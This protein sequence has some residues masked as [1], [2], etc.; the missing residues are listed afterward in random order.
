MSAWANTATAPFRWRSGVVLALTSIAG[1]I[2]FTWPLFAHPR[3]SENLAHA[4]DAPW[5]FLLVLPLLLAVLLT[6][7]TDGSL[8]AK[9]VAVLGVL[10]ACGAALRTPATGITG[11]TGV[12]FLL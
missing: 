7:L 4:A 2:G 9:A 6:E 3:G 11:F 8:D 12:F 1:V 5:L 10:V